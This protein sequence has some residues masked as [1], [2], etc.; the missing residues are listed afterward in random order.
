[1]NGLTEKPMGPGE[2]MGHANKPFL[3][4]A[5]IEPIQVVNQA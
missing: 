4:K 3:K 1:M 5:L 2:P